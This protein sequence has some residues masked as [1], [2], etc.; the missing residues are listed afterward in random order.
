MARMT[1]GK[2]AERWGATVVVDNR[3]G[4]NTIIGNSIVAKA[5]P[6]G[7]TMA[8]GGP[9]LQRACHPTNSPANAPCGLAST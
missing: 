1:A 3:P 9:S 8:W 2:L 5:A 7:Y 6:D 4:G